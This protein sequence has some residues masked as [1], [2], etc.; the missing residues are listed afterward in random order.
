VKV[1]FTPP[2]REVSDTTFA[3]SDIQWRH[4][5]DAAQLPSCTSESATTLLAA[6]TFDE[7]CMQENKHCPPGTKVGQHGDVVV[8]ATP[9]RVTDITCCS[10][11]VESGLNSAWPE[12][13]GRMITEV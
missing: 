4:L 6:T 3:L 8:R 7:S 1:H 2:G 10:A 13:Q 9:N 5:V 11:T 12:C